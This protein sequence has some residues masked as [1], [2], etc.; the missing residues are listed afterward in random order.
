MASKI[1]EMK[2]IGDDLSQA[3][4]LFKQEMNLYLEDED[5]AD[6]AKK[7]RKICRGIGDEGLLRLNASGISDAD[8]KKM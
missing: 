1:P 5:I 4:S 6:S 3:L 2:W 7:A 8:K